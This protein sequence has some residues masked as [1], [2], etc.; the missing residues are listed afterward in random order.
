M[1][2]QNLPYGGQRRKIEQTH[3]SNLTPTISFQ[4]SPDRHTPYTGNHF[5]LLTFAHFR[6]WHGYA[7][8]AVSI[9][10]QEEGLIGVEL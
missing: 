10:Y 7:H 1:R 9:H 8:R 2:A 5:M 4:M 3:F 6:N